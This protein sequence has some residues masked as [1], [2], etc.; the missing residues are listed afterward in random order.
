MTQLQVSS[1][2]KQIYLGVHFK[3]TSITICDLNSSEK[4]FESYLIN[5]SDKELDIQGGIFPLII[6]GLILGPTIEPI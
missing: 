3:M 1:Q 5:L 6:A 2:K 4:A